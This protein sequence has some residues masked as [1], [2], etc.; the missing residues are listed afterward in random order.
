MATDGSTALE[1]LCDVVEDGL[2]SRTPAPN[3]RGS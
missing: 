2:G 3:G 1:Y